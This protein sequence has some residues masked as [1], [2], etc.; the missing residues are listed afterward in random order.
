MFSLFFSSYANEELSN[1]TLS[2]FMTSH[3]LPWQQLSALKGLSNFQFFLIIYKT[4]SVTYHFYCFFWNLLTFVNFSNEI[5]KSY[6]EEL[7]LCQ[8]RQELKYRQVL[9]IDFPENFL[10]KRACRVLLIGKILE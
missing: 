9:Y 1:N 6:R 2:M 10:S 7:W 8:I 4:K 5:R 3:P